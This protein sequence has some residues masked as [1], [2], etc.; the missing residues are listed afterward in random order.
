[1]DTIRPEELAERVEAG[2]D[3]FVLDV[4][5]ES[6]FEAYHIAESYNA[7]VYH[8]LEADGEALEPFL[9]DLPRESLIVTVC[10]VGACARDATTALT[11]RG[12]E[13]VTLKGGIRNWKG[14]D[15]GTL[16]Y[17]I[18]TLLRNSFSS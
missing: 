8:E 5:P 2:E 13:A 10:R 18:K 3:I 17:R 12:F 16:G 9:D 11:D 15:Q 6:E 4:R 14:Y 1:M 7:P